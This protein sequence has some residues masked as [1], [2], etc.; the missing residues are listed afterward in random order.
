MKFFILAK[1]LEHRNIELTRCGVWN[2][3]STSWIRTAFYQNIAKFQIWKPIYAKGARS[4][5]NKEFDLVL[6]NCGASVGRNL[7]IELKSCYGRVAT[8]FGAFRVQMVYAATISAE[9]TKNT[10]Q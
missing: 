6:V 10:A 2:I 9:Q 1:I 7:V 3:V 5:A 4:F 8:V